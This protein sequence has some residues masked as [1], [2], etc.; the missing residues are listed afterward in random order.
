LS[1]GDI[2]TG[3]LFGFLRAVLSLQDL[4][5]TNQMVFAFDCGRSL[6][7]IDYPGY[8][9]RRDDG[10]T[11]YEM[12]LRD[13]T[14]MQIKFLRKVYLPE[15]GFKNVF[16]QRGYE[17]DDVIAGVCED[18][19]ANYPRDRAIIVSADKDLWQLL[20]PRV[21]CYNATSKTTTT[22]DSFRE[23]FGIEPSAW[24]DCKALAGCKTDDVGGIE[25]IGE[26]TAA[27]YLAGNLKPTSEA[28]SKIVK[29]HWIWQRNLPIV[30]I[31]YPGLKKFKLQE[32]NVSA[33]VWQEF[34]EKLGFKSM[35]G[36]VPS[37]HRPKKSIKRR[38]GFGFA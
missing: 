28:Y 34:A 7:K 27:K 29:G 10:K 25:G 8:K 17:A 5:N 19:K 15:L 36:N 32:D 20:S 3:V 35:M 21:I 2:K 33:K 37:R 4:H 6:R 23:R 13:E 14:R 26:I 11:D 22:L 12:D 9:S 16:Y 24:S 30:S 31:P 1:Y 38:R 18:L